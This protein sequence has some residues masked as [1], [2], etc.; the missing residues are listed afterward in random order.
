MDTLFYLG[1]AVLI[2]MVAL[3]IVYWGQKLHIPGLSLFGRMRRFTFLC[4][5]ILLTVLTIAFDSFTASLMRSVT[6]LPTYWAVRALIIFG[7]IVLLP[8]YYVIYTRRLHDLSLPG[9]P[10]LIWGVFLIFTQSYITV[11]ATMMMFT[12][13][14]IIVN[15]ILI[16]I[17]GWEKDNRF[18]PGTRQKKERPIAQR[19]RSMQVPPPTPNPMRKSSRNP[20]ELPQPIRRLR[21]H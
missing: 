6:I 15:L 5:L 3:F 10:A 7:Y 12:I 20:C 17:P 13:I 11:K 16:I 9:S 1:Q 21:R 18:G 14:I 4:Y 2:G 19:R 8:F